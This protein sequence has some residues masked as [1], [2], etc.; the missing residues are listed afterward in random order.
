LAQLQKTRENFC[1]NLPRPTVDENTPEHEKQKFILIGSHPKYHNALL[2]VSVMLQQ[3]IQDEAI[4]EK[5]TIE[6]I[7]KFCKYRL[8]RSKESK[9]RTVPEEIEMVHRTLNAAIESIKRTHKL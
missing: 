4:R 2:K 8:E 5:G 6:K 7:D 3:A 1:S 9:R